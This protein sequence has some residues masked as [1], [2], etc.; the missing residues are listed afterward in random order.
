M[1]KISLEIGVIQLYLILKNIF[2][3]FIY[4][5]IYINIYFYINPEYDNFIFILPPSVAITPLLIKHP[6]LN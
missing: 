2:I 6:I 3:S 1:I 5:C 4:I